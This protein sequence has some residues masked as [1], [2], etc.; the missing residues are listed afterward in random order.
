MCIRDSTY[1][2]KED[3][4]GTVK[5]K[6]RQDLLNIWNSNDCLED[7]WLDIIENQLDDEENT[8]KW[9]DPRNDEIEYIS[10]SDF[11]VT[12]DDF[13]KMVIDRY[14]F[15]NPNIAKYFNLKGKK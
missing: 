8:K 15:E 9:V 7:K 12:R 10:N 4:F 11:E 1:W 5:N 6:G 14:M 2:I 13:L 3:G